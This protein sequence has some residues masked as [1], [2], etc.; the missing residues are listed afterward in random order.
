MKEGRGF[1]F[2][3]II[4]HESSHFNL[5]FHHIV[6]FYGLKITRPNQTF[7][8]NI[9]VKKKTND[10]EENITPYTRIKF[11][12]TISQ[13]YFNVEGNVE[14]NLIVNFLLQIL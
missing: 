1:L 10:S 13:S 5:F 6:Y 14:W 3:N 12:L 2:S 9:C 11:L 7:C 8:Y 4:Y